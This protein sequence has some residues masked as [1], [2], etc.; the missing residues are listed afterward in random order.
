MENTSDMLT[1]LAGSGK[2]RAVPIWEL[3][4]HLWEKFAEM[5]V[6]FGV[7]FEGLSASQQKRMIRSNAD[8]ILSVSEQLNF[9]AVTVPGGYWEVANGRP[10]FYWLPEPARFSLTEILAKEKPGPLLLVANIGGVLAM[11]G[12]DRFVGFSLRLLED[13]DSIDR[14][15]DQCLDQGLDQARRFIDAGVGCICSPSDIADNR[16]LFFN[17]GQMDRFILPHLREWASA[18]RRMGAFPILHTDG[19]V[20]AVLDALADSGIAALQAVDPL[21]GMDM[22]A[23]MKTVRGRIALCG[24]VDC[25]LLVA[26]SP[27]SVRQSAGDILLSCKGGN[28]F[29]FGASNAVQREVPKENYE[30]MIDAWK[31]H[32]RVE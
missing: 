28:G 8:A 13:P 11:P 22:K 23:A 26:G 19:D 9:S 15:A 5:P 10:A 1:V 17:P 25:G 2:I 29:V 14:E 27:D 7:E 30:A 31:A 20:S 3:E 21:A 24:N 32:G 18:V 6:A 12:G 4:F 16:G